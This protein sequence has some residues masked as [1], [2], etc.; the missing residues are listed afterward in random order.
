MGLPHFKY[1]SENGNSTAIKHFKV[2]IP[3]L[4]EGKQAYQKKLKEEKKK[5]NE[6]A[7]VPS[8]L[9]DTSG[10]PATNTSWTGRQ[11][12]FPPS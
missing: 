12:N 10:R 9:H 3:N 1:A 6:A 5:G 2:E 8:I 4:K 11:I 7:K